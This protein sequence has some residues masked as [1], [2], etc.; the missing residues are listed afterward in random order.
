MKSNA[1][2]A[3]LITCFNRKAKTLES[4]RLLFAQDLPPDVSLQVYL[5]DDG[6]TDGTGEAI[7]QTYP[8]VTI[9]SGTGSLFWNGGMK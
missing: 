5:V 8:Q 2:I 1:T 4:L 3:V 7:A 6:S 9:L